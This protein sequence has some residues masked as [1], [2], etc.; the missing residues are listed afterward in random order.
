MQAA[1][2]ELAA[3][4]AGKPPTLRKKPAAGKTVR[5]VGLALSISPTVFVHA[6][7]LIIVLTL[8]AL[9]LLGCYAIMLHSFLAG[10]AIALPAGI[11]ASL[12]ASYASACYLGIVESTSAGHTTVDDALQ[13]DWRDWFW[14][15]PMTLGMAA[16]AAAIG[17]AISLAAPD[18]RWTI[19][20]GSTLLLAPILQLSS[21]EAGSPLAP[22]SPPVLRSLVTRP[23]AWFAFYAA[24]LL[25]AIATIGL[26]KAA[27]R[28]PP[29]VTLLIVAPIV[30]VLLLVYAWLLGQLAC[31]ISI[32]RPEPQET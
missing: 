14:S 2:A 10:R 21:L 6:I 28:D 25:I 1:H 15:L 20:G 4:D 8:A 5:P 29:F 30:T 13:G 31:W 12:A 22:F 26:A 24:S 23:L 32:E 17:Y 3:K 18:S 9:A 16:A 19:I 27:W 7:L 11:L